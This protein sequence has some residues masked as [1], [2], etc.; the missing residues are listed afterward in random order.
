MGSFY[1][2]IGLSTDIDFGMFQFHVPLWSMVETLV[3]ELWIFSLEV[4]LIFRKNQ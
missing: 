2:L 1:S 4:E 3:D